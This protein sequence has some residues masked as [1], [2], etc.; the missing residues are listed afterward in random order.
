MKK[1]GFITLLVL[2]ACHLS[3]QE[4]ATPQASPTAILKQNFSTGFIELSYSRPSIK[5]R[6]IFGNLV[7]Y[8][9]VWR[10]GAN[11]AT[12][13]TFSNDVTIGGKLI[14][15]GKYGLLSIPGQS[16]WILIIT[17]DLDVTSPAAYK[18][19]ND[20]VRVPVT[21][22]TLPFS[23][24]SMTIEFADI[25]GNSLNL[26]IYWDNTIVTLPITTNTE[27]RVMEQIDNAMNK[28]NR[29][30]YA[31]AQFYYDN[32]KDLKKAEEW[33]NKAVTAEPDA[34]WMQLLK[35]RI[36]V[37]NGDK[38]GAKAAAQKTIEIA[39]RAKN[40][41]YVKLATDLLKGL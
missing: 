20:V 7:P 9:K 29:P 31:A 1:I 32:G 3:A 21:P 19:E 24:E 4:I 34:Y 14:K 18:P 23:I 16:N 38:A 10:T 36:L 13:L 26:V 2:C 28:D 33:I 27:S 22:Q 8:D 15:A 37:K 35:A 30:Y 11:S 41:D 25:T 17:K 39:T 12:T 6:T 40:N 5:G